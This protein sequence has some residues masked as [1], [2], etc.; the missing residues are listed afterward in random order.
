[1][2]YLDKVMTRPI[3]APRPLCT[4]V[5]HVIDANCVLEELPVPAGSRWAAYRA[6]PEHPITPPG[7]TTL[8]ISRVYS[9]QLF[10]LPDLWHWL[11]IRRHDGREIRE[12]RDE[13][14]AIKDEIVGSDVWAMEAFPPRNEVINAANMRHLWL[15]P[16]G[17]TLPIDLSGGRKYRG[18]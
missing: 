11:A 13:L 1:M 10:E 9:V 15:V 8:W 16:A 14:Q 2:N 3:P 12:R 17:T 7:V 5:G 4:R 6:N 18:N